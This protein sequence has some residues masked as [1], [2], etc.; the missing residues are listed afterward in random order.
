[1]DSQ[2]ITEI[3][4]Q[5][6][7]NLTLREE[8][9]KSLEESREVILNGGVNCIPIP[10]TR[11]RGDFPGIRKKFYYVISG[12]TKSSKTQLTN[13]LFIITP[14]FYYMEHPD[15]IK[16]KIFYFPLEETKEDITLRFYSYVL[17]YIT[18]GRVII[19]PE[20]LES[21]DERKPLSQEVLDLM[22]SEEFIKI[23]NVFE[24]CVEFH[25]DQKNPTG[26]Y[27]T[28]KSYLDNNGT[29]EYIEKDITYT[30][31]NGNI[32]KERIRKANKYIPNNPKEY[33]IYITDHAGL[34]QVERGMTLKETIEKLSEYNML[35]RNNY[36]AIPVL[37]QQQNAETTNLDAYKAN[38]IRPTKDGL[39]D[40]KR[41]G[42]DCTVLIGITNPYSFGVPDYLGYNIQTLKDN[43]R[44]MEIVLSRKGR[45][46]GICPLYFNGAINQ[47]TELPL[48]ND[49]LGIEK[50]YSYLEN[51]R[52]KST[53]F[54]ISEIK[55]KLQRK[56]KI[57]IFAKLFNKLKIF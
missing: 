41:P 10:F 43:F 17:Y 53:T 1:M 45:A 40:S 9:K 6:S 23:A 31:D 55:N 11:F 28:V 3:G 24:E 20:D 52:K 2:K 25:K 44:V 13:F 33:V 48:P 21:V 26:I 19:S 49:T 35:L 16:P 15:Q 12:A 51:L 30:D 22:D 5:N 54:F 50:V 38:K 56:N 14:L 42:E 4:Q 47:Y 18:N 37:V 27:K 29:I 34:L 46:N 57:S 8:I 7:D 36:S 32:R 39:K